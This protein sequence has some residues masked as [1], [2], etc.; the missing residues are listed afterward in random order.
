MNTFRLTLSVILVGC[1]ASGCKKDDNPAA[2]PLLGAIMPLKVGNSWTF[3]VSAYDSS[4]VILPYSL[5]DITLSI[6]RD[7]TIG[8]EQWFRLSSSWVT[9]RTDGLWGISD[10]GNPYLVFKYP[11]KLN[12]AYDSDGNNVIVSSTNQ[13]VSVPQGQFT[14]YAYSYNSSGMVNTVQ[15]CAPDVGMVSIESYQRSLSG[16]TYVS[17]R[18]ELKT[19]TLNH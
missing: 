13:S 5:G 6:S 2:N 16:R 7:T 12:D 8:N 15:Y 18:I 1:I 14:C 11:A 19:L 3:R 10:A 17:G 9:N 4:G